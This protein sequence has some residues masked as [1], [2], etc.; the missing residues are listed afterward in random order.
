ME[1]SF[2][3][4]LFVAAAGLLAVVSFGVI[5]LTAVEWRDRRRQERDKK[6]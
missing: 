5:Y 1:S 3:S 2:V 6:R 4:F